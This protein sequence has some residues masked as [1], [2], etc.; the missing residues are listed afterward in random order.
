MGR[1]RYSMAVSLD[2]LFEGPDGD[3]SWHHVDAE[4]HQHVNDVLRTAR[5]FLDGR[6][7]YELMADFWPTADADPAG[8]PE[9]REFAGIW[10]EMPKLVYTRT[11][12]T[13]GWNST[14]VRDVDPIAVR[15]LAEEGD[16]VVGGAEL[17]ATFFRRGL[18]D[19]VCLYVMPVVLGVGRRLFPDDLPLTFERRE[20]RSFGN[21]VVLL[22]YAVTSASDGR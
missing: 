9:M 3:L 21:G 12:A 11:L 6:R 13:V 8:E 15:A 19:E 18:I 10:R 20:A 7:T 1:I 5:A 16:L 2:G 14:I 4:L 22:R 17:A